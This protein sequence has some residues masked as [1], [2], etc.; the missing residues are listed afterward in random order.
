MVMVLDESDTDWNDSEEEMSDSEDLATSLIEA[1]EDMVDPLRVAQDISNDDDNNEPEMITTS[2][3]S[4]VPSMS[5]TSG[6]TS[7]PTPSSASV[8][9]LP[10]VC[11]QP[12]MSSNVPELSNR[13]V[14][15]PFAQPVGPTELL[16][17]DSTP[18]DFFLQIFGKD[19]FDHIAEQTNLY[20]FQNPPSARYNWTDT[21]PQE[22]IDS[23]LAI[24]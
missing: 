24:S 23:T 9:S 15:I 12:S 8:L 10:S 4:Q 19:T 16:D 18:L 3:T 2:I 14:P 20:A 5:N 6:P 11:Q 7:L 21:N 13:I 22:L 1:Q 17:S